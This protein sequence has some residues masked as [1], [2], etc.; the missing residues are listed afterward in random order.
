MI[1][2]PKFFFCA[3]LFYWASIQ[4]LNAQMIVG[5]D[6]LYGNEWIRYSNAYLRIKVAADGMYRVNGAQLAAAGIAA[7][8]TGAD[9][10][11]YRNGKQVPIFTTTEGVIGDQ[12]FMEFWGQ[13]TRDEVDQFLFTDAAAENVNPWYSLT[14]DTT[15]YFLTWQDGSAPLRYAPT[16][17]DLSN[18]PASTPWCWFTNLQFFTNGYCGK[19]ASLV[20]KTKLIFERLSINLI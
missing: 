2:H 3:C 8:T 20:T 7:G 12:D 6:T 1:H 17:N 4:V 5:A 16:P 14:N 10:R 15:T 18:V 19:G 9:L 11:L 13:R